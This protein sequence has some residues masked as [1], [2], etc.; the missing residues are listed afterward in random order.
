MTRETHILRLPPDRRLRR[1]GNATLEM[2]LVLG[3]LLSL[4]FGAVEFGHFFFVKNTLQGAAREG[5]RAAITAAATNADVQTAVNNSLSAAGFNLAQ[6]TIRIRNATD[7]ADV[8]V[9]TQPAGAGILVRV[10]GTWGTVGIRPMGMLD[11]AKVVAGAA[12]M[13]KE[14][15]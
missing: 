5:A 13:R 6:Y 12:V 8:N 7:T 14:S 9:A 2:T 10:S 4:T 11:P 3:L 1:R 15:T